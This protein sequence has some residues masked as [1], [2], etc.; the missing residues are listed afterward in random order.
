MRQRSGRTW[1]PSRGS[2]SAER[3]VPDPVALWTSSVFVEEA[4]AWVAAQLAP[5]GSRL[6]GEWEQPHARVWSSTIRFETT[7]GRVW[8]K[9]N[10]SGTA[11]EAALIAVLGELR[12]GLAPDVIAHDDNRGGR[13]PGT[14]A[15]YSDP[16]WRPMRLAVLGA[17]SAPVC[18][19]AARPR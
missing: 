9:V 8:F 4:R 10:G 7:E 18:R 15:R 14:G 11:Y 19:G 3:V 12:P 5:R 16:S 13:S 1:R 2:L 17:A 6:T